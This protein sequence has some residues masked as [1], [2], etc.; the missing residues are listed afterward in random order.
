[1]NNFLNFYGVNYAIINSNKDE[2]KVLEHHILI[3]NFSYSFNPKVL[4]LKENHKFQRA[5][6]SNRIQTVEGNNRKKTL[7]DQYTFSIQLVYFGSDKLII[8]QIQKKE[9]INYSLQKNDYA[10]A[11]GYISKF[12]KHGCR[13][14]KT[15]NYQQ[16]I[17]VFLYLWMLKPLIQLSHIMF[18]K[19]IG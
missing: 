9:C 13:I 7:T 19:K 11:Y 12:E 15:V 4:E 8:L 18:G 1:M 5:Q 14:K 16:R 10:I 6:Y 2:C 3:Y 17:Q